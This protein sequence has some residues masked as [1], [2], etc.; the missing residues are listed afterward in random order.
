M[1]QKKQKAKGCRGHEEKQQHH[2]SK[3]K[4]KK[5]YLSLYFSFPTNPTM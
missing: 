4:K 5:N 2:Q 1:K 3:K